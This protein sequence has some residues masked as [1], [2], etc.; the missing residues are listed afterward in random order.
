MELK[1]PH[2]LQLLISFAALLSAKVVPVFPLWGT[3]ISVSS[4][5][6]HTGHSALLNLS[7]DDGNDIYTHCVRGTMFAH[8]LELSMR[9]A[10]VSTFWLL[11]F[12][13]PF[14]LYHMKPKLQ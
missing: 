7:G 14:F 9:S 6:A 1:N 2:H 8:A 4:S 12:A 11:S 5:V 13:L 3:E 10:C